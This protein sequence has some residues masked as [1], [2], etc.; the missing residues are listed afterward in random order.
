MA[1]IAILIYPIFCIIFLLENSEM[2]DFIYKFTPTQFS[3]P[4]LGHLNMNLTLRCCSNHTEEKKKKTPS[5]QMKH[6]NKIYLMQKMNRKY[7]NVMIW[8]LLIDSQDIARLIN[9]LAMM[10]VSCV[11]YC[12]C[13]DLMMRMMMMIKCGIKIY[14]VFE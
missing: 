2:F 12:F 14:F 10:F 9:D 8:C 4:N 1:I 3:E 6:Q 13:F 11:Y 5:N 7:F